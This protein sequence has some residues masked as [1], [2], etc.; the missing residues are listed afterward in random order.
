MAH[1]EL[2]YGSFRFILTLTLNLQPEYW[3]SLY[4]PKGVNPMF[5]IINQSMPFADAAA[6]G[7][8]ER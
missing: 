3:S 1:H 8:D 2:C 5:R 6:F 4:K 7:G